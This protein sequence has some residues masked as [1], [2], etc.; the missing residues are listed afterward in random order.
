MSN[1]TLYIDYASI[2]YR[3]MHD[4]PV[5]PGLH[6][7]QPSSSVHVVVDEAQSQLLSQFSPQVPVAHAAGAT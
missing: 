3:Y 2:K 7:S 4:L 5:Q 1:K 6:A